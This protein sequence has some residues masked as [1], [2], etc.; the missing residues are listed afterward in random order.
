[1][2]A[3]TVVDLTYK[4]CCALMGSPPVYAML[5]RIG[6]QLVGVS[7]VN[8][9]LDIYSGGIIGG[10]GAGVV[11]GIVGGNSAC[12][13]SPGCPLPEWA[14]QRVAGVLCT[15]CLGGFVGAAWPIL[16]PAYIADKVRRRS[17]GKHAHSTSQ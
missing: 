8:T 11:Y 13:P 1:V 3:R 10:A 6:K 15:A 14:M 5:R 17:L 12:D 2:F 7:R 16:A 9:A 4:Q